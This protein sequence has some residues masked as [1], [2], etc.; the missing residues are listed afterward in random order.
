MRPS[1]AVGA[2]EGRAPQKRE[3]VQGLRE[4]QT[5]R[6]RDI[7][8]WSGRH[9]PC[10]Q[11]PA[12]TDLS[13][14]TYN[15]GLP[16]F[17]RSIVW[18]QKCV[19]T[20]LAPACSWGPASLWSASSQELGRSPSGTP[21]DGTLWEC[22]DL[23]HFAHEKGAIVISI[24]QMGKR[25]L[26]KRGDLPLRATWL[27]LTEFTFNS[28]PYCQLLGCGDTFPEEGGPRQDWGCGW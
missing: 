21:A 4:G 26:G 24:L 11:L 10:G 14:P 13:F 18:E 23:P 8:S 19:Q 9:L 1:R 6:P 27:H 2:G 22:P 12:W 15:M 3:Q 20:P 28:L 17:I 16:G 7:W 5:W 25:R